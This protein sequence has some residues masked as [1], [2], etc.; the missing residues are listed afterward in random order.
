MEDLDRILGKLFLIGIH[1]TSLNKENMKALNAI[2]P[3][4]IIFFSRN[5]Q[6]KNQLHKFIEDIKNFLGYEPL[7]SIDQEGGMVTRLEKVF[8]LLQV[9]WLLLPQTIAKTLI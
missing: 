5:V 9:L 6:H 3:G 1:G 7:F 4:A 8:L 2:K